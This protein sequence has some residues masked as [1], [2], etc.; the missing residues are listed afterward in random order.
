VPRPRW[1]LTGAGRSSS[2][3]AP[4]S[5]R[6]NPTDEA[7]RGNSPMGSSNG[8]VDRSRACDG[9]RL[10]PTFGDE[11]QR[12][13]GDEIRLRGGIVRCRRAVWC[14]L[15]AAGSPTEQRRARVAGRVSIFANQNSL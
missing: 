14:W 15:G 9:G 11:L 12:S 10:A 13:A 6:F 2:Y 5:M 8:R 4:F 3:G 1:W 7:H